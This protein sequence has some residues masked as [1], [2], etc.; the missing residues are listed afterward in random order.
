MA[1]YLLVIVA[2][3]P[4]LERDAAAPHAK[5]LRDQPRNDNLHNDGIV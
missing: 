2:E 4:H 3:A 1:T 5:M